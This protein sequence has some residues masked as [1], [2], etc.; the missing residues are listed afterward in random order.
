MIVV[1]FQIDNMELKEVHI[2][3]GVKDEYK[4]FSFSVERLK[5]RDSFKEVVRI[6]AFYGLESD[7]VKDYVESN[8]KYMGKIVCSINMLE[9]ELKK[10]GEIGIVMSVNGCRDLAKLIENNYY[11]FEVIRQEGIENDVP[12]ELINSVVKHY[13]EY[14]S[15]NKIEADKNGLYNITVE[16]FT[17]EYN[18]CTYNIP[19]IKIKEALRLKEYTK[20]NLNRNDY[21]IKITENG[22]TATKRHISFYKDKIDGLIGKMNKTEGAAE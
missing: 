10:L 15:D 1:T 5:D 9:G 22:K 12:D 3:K 18:E 8:D 20:C 17:K 2:I 19:I 4:Q 14:I 7:N 21:N 6:R 13:A 11:N 16:E